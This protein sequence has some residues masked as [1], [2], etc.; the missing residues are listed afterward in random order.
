VPR[1]R[2]QSAL[3]AVVSLTQGTEAGTIYSLEQIAD[4]CRLAHDNGLLVHMDGARFSNALV[5]L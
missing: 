3:P 5:A 1:G 4:I 2:P